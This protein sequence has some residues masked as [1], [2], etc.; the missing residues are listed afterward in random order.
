MSEQVRPADPRGE[1][2]QCETDPGFTQWM[3]ACGGSLAI[4]TYQAGKLF[5]VGWNGQQISFLARDFDRPMGLDTQGQRLA[6]V[7]TNAVTVFANAPKLA[8][9]YLEKD[10]YDALY[11]PRAM[12]VMPDL[13]IHDMAFAG[14]I[15][16]VVNTQCSCLA[17]LSL[18]QTF[19]PAWQP[20]FIDSLAAEDRCHLNGMAMVDGRPRYVTMLSRTNTKGGWR[21][22]KNDGGLVMDIDNNEVL[23]DGLAMPHS[24]RWHDGHLWV[25]NSGQGR[26]LR[27]DGKGGADVVCELQGYLRG[28]CFVN[29]YALIGL[30]KIRESNVF[31]GMPVQK[32]HPD[33]LCGI[34]IVSLRTGAL[35]GML[36]L[37]SGC[38]EIYDIRFLPG[39]L[40]PNVVNLAMEESRKGVDIPGLA[41]WLASDE[42][43]RQMKEERADTAAAVKA[44]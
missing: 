31:G 43:I 17:K 12:F 24:P 44:R 3:S 23:L 39:V 13:S 11:L 5:L 21:E 35:V 15:L 1:R 16:W 41:V 40:R 18:D 32:R 2:L 25:L 26:L 22:H 14:D 33:L 27:L 6:L 29:G 4:S 10:R 37:T 38:T 30:C 8:P 9:L 20:P 42:K 34:A 28:L 36:K 19:E 7:T